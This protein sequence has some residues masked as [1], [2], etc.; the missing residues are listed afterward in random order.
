V[1]DNTPYTQEDALT[2][3]M[4]DPLFRKLK[5]TFDLQLDFTEDA[6]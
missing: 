4:S 3:L 5:E 2:E 6:I 1:K